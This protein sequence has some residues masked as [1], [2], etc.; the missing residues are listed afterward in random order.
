[1]PVTRAKSLDK[2]DSSNTA[3]LAQLANDPEIMDLVKKKLA[4]KKID[5]GEAKLNEIVD[6]TRQKIDGEKESE[7]WS[8][9]DGQELVKL[10]D[11][12]QMSDDSDTILKLINKL[13]EHKLNKHK[14]NKWGP[15][16]LIMKMEL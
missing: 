12:D 9:T 1:M 16:N 2:I 15:V 6:L 14:L 13:N 4:S 8:T 7:Y 11:E 3:D 5:P 10:N